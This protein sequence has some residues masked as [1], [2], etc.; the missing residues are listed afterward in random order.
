MTPPR[1]DFT[2]C[3]PDNSDMSAETKEALH[4]IVNAAGDRMAAM[5]VVEQAPERW[6]RELRE[7]GWAPHRK[8][9]TI[10][11]DPDGRLYIGPFGAWREMK[12]RAT[13]A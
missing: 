3:N 10:W 13:A 7:A 5:P 1:Y 12:R 6:V 9:H 8:S 11:S 2:T 4:R